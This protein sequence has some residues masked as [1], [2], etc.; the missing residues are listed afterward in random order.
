[1]GYRKF[2]FTRRKNAE[3]KRL[4]SCKLKTVIGRPYKH[5]KHPVEGLIQVYSLNLM[6]DTV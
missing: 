6:R 3:R 2:T 1:M 5:Q 4:A